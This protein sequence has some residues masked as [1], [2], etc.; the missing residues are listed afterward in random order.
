MHLLHLAAGRDV[1]GRGGEKASHAPTPPAHQ[2]LTTSTKLNAEQN[3]SWQSSRRI[4][5]RDLSELM[6]GSLPPSDRFSSTEFF[7]SLLLSFSPNLDEFNP[8][9]PEWRQDVGRVIKKALLQVSDFHFL[10]LSLSGISH[11]PPPA[12]LQLFFSG[13]FFFSQNSVLSCFPAI[14]THPRSC[15]AQYCGRVAAHLNLRQQN[16]DHRATY[17]TDGKVSL[18]PRHLNSLHSKSLPVEKS[19]KY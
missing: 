6:T 19:R 18:L 15:A 8:D 11:L 7:K 1:R 5:L 3:D 10:C 12:F 17:Q 14:S 13:L 2:V 16:W 4:T 9:I